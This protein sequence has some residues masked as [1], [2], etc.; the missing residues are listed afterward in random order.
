[1][2]QK[3]INQLYGSK[4]DTENSANSDAVSSKCANFDKVQF[5]KHVVKL[6]TDIIQSSMNYC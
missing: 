1:V 3:G 5:Y 2:S 4:P 6:I